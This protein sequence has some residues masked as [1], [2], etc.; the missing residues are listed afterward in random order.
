[1]LRVWDSVG[2]GNAALLSKAKIIYYLIEKLESI[3]R[4][5]GIRLQSR[6]MDISDFRAVFAT[7]FDAL[8]TLNSGNANMKTLDRRHQN[9]S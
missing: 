5:S 2:K 9:H 7:A 1:M 6:Q 4:E 8:N 3:A